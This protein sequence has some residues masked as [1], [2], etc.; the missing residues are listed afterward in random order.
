VASTEGSAEAGLPVSTLCCLFVLLHVLSCKLQPFLQTSLQTCFLQTSFLQVR[1]GQR[2]VLKKILEQDLPSRV[3][4]VLMVSTIRTRDSSSKQ[5]QQQNDQQQQRGGG[6][7]GAQAE[8]AAAAAA[9]VGDV[10]GIQLSDGWYAVNA[11]LDAP[12][13]EL[14][15]EGRIQV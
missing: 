5:Q 11:A 8:P 14:V 3:P 15:M 6:R 12:L 10:Q 2:S 1:E 9:V 7:G 4:L 13:T